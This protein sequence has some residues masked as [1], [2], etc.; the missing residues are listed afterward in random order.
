MQQSLYVAL[1]GQVARERRLETVAHNV[2]NIN[3]P[4]FRAA[5][6]SFSA[7]LART[8]GVQTAFSWEGPD[9]ISQ[10]NGSLTK[11]DNPLDVATRGNAWF[12]IKTETGP[13]YTRDGRMRMAET[14]ALETI[15]GDAVLDAGGGPIILDTAAGAPQ[16][17]PDGMITQGGKQLAAIG[18]FALDPA[19]RLS[20]SAGS[21]VVS[22]AAAT[23]VL[24]FSV[25]GVAQ[26]YIETSNVDPVL[27]MTKMISLSREYEAINTT[28]F[29]T[30]SSLRDAIKTLA[31]NS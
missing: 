17:A 22:S 23:A 15:N 10:R 4:G 27:E 29:Q 28:I 2:S 20:R 14:G 24:D 31:A 11:T 21:S 19:A 25:N 13:A 12:G 26:G 8:G 16:I 1:S 30:E 3:T 9:F 6:I 18:L 7:E 5:G